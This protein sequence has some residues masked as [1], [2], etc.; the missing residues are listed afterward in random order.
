[1][2]DSPNSRARRA[3]GSPFAIPRRHRTKVAGRCRVFAK[4]V[5]VSSMMYPKNRTTE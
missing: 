5:P 2:R 1:L 3:V 4:T